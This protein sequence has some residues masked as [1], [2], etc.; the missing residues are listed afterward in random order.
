MS[1]CWALDKKKSKTDM[2]VKRKAVQSRFQW[3]AMMN[4]SLLFLMDQWL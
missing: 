2:L 4:I 1:E 3:K